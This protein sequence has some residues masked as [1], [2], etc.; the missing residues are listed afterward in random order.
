MREEEMKKDENLENEGVETQGL[1]PEEGKNDP[2]KAGDGGSDDDKG[3]DK[4]I[5]GGGSNGLP[6]KK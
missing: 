3:E 1:V 4:P 6:V 2:D 5:I